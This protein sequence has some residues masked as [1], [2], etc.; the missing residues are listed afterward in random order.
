MTPSQ[1]IRTECRRCRGGQLFRCESKSCSLNRPGRPRPKIKAHCRECN[2]DDHPEDC[3]GRL[4]DGTTCNLYESRVGK[5][6]HAKKRT[7]SPEH[8]AK[9][10]EAGRK[11][12][13]HTG[14]NTSSVPAGLTVTLPGIPEA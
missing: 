3:T 12:R 5:N 9:L 8:K 7:L 6:P 1:A 14:L 10:A 4:L 11:H 13:F 2:G